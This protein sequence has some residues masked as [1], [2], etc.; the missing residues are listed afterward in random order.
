MVS[1]QLTDTSDPESYDWDPLDAEYL[2]RLSVQKYVSLSRERRL[3]LPVP[4]IGHNAQDSSK[5]NS[6][7][8]RGQTQGNS[9]ALDTTSNHGWDGIAT[10]RS[11]SL[12]DR[13]MPGIPTP[14][15]LMAEV[16]IEA[17]QYRYEGST[18]PARVS[19][20]STNAT[21]L[22]YCVIDTLYMGVKSWFL[23]RQ[24]RLANRSVAGYIGGMG[25]RGDERPDLFPGLCG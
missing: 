20:S 24:S 8:E 15:Q 4:P 14:E 10:S 17:V 11:A 6:H 23:D 7:S 25:S 18:I 13:N 19:L 3:G 2:A 22:F 21:L 16:P 1:W 9:G 5:G 12:F